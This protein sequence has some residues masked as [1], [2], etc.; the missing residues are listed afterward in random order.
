MIRCVTD[1][2]VTGMKLTIPQVQASMEVFYKANVT[3][4]LFVDNWYNANGMPSGSKLA[5]SPRAIMLTSSCVS[6]RP[7]YRRWGIRQRLRVFFK[8]VGNE[9]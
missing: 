2:P 4:G 8:A 1:C 5:V 6:K 7:H 3:N 9:W